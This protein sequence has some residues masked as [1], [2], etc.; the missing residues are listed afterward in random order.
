MIKAALR[1]I[2][3]ATLDNGDKHHRAFG[4]KNFNYPERPVVLQPEPA[5]QGALAQGQRP[6]PA[7]PSSG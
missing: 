3:S 1:L 5:H 7:S 2:A 6:I 4:K